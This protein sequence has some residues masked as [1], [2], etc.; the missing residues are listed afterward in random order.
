ML[1]PP[2]MLREVGD[3]EWF[4]LE[5]VEALETDAHDALW[6]LA[7]AGYDSQGY[8]FQARPQTHARP[9]MRGLFTTE[10]TI[11]QIERV[12]PAP[13]LAGATAIAQTLVRET[14]AGG[15]V[16]IA[17]PPSTEWI[18]AAPLPALLQFM[19]D[20]TIIDG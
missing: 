19:V 6:G 18:M 17:A 7:Y 5:S 13:D 20:A 8:A 2:L 9:V 11:W 14:I 10:S 12:A 15:A 4:V 1:C 16:R 3:D